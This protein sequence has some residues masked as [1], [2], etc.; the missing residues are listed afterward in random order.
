[1]ISQLVDDARSDGQLP[2]APFNGGV[3]REQEA[4]MKRERQK[5]NTYIITILTMQNKI[6][7]SGD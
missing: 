5:G 3:F 2:N 4:E 1:M 7:N 6:I